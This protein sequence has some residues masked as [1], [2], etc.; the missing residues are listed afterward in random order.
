MGGCEWL[1]VVVG[2]CWSLVVVDRGWCFGGG[3]WLLL[4]LLFRLSLLLLLLL[5]GLGG[6]ATAVE[7]PHYSEHDH[8]DK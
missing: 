5:I 1:L 4:L 8:H 2:G 6:D 3:W 7:D